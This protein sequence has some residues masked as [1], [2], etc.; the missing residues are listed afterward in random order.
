MV[1]VKTRRALPWLVPW[2][3]MGCPAA[4]PVLPEQPDAGSSEEGGATSRGMEASSGESLDASAGPGTS[5]GEAS[6]GDEPACTLSEGACEAGAAPWWDPA[7]AHRRRIEVGPAAGEALV[8][9]VVPVR[10]G[11]GFEYGC[12]RADG[13]DLRFVGDDGNVMAHELDEWIVGSTSVAWVRIAS[14]DPGG[15]AFWLYHGNEAASAEPAE[16]WSSALGYEA[17][18]HLGGDLED[19][20]GLHDAKPAVGDDGPFYVDDGVVGRAVHYEDILVDA[21]AELSGSEA[22]DDAILASESFTIAAWIR[23]TPDV[24]SSSRFRS[25][26]SRGSAHWSLTV[27]DPVGDFDFVPPAPAS[28]VTRCHVTECEGSVDAFG[29]HFLESTAAVVEHP[30]IARW[31]HVAAT[32]EAVASG[33]H[34]KRLYVDGELD[35]EV[36]EPLPLPWG[37]MALHTEPLTLGAGPLNPEEAVFHGEIDEVRIASR[38]WDAERIRAEHAYAGQPE[39]VTVGPAEC[40]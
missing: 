16:V 13:A 6:T 22:I 29:N 12:A 27:H 30:V 11:A 39:L 23:A 34:A 7:W 21:R 31:H 32:Y 20:R 2:L 9:A 14:L 10:L 5:G 18:L 3:V 28:F 26:V 33:E 1:P 24:A 8:D 17:V 19:A 38:A 40:R 36:V 25:V 37:M 4:K 35:A 15:A